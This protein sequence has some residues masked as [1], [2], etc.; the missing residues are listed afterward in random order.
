[1]SSALKNAIFTAP[2]LW[3]AETRKK[4]DAIV[5]KY[6]ASNKDQALQLVILGIGAVSRFCVRYKVDSSWQS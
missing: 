4:L 5:K 1:M 3:P 2:D 6:A